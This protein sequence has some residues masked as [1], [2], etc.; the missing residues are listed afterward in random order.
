MQ[1]FGIYKNK[2][3]YT[4]HDFI[5]NTY[6]MRNNVQIETKPWHNYSIDPIL[7]H[8]VTTMTR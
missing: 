4:K 3:V 7:L 1:S 5:L 8:L 2:Y 6:D